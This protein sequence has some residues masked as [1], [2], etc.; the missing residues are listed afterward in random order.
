MS[1]QPSESGI[2]FACSSRDSFDSWFTIFTFFEKNVIRQSTVE[3]IRDRFFSQVQRLSCRGILFEPD[4]AMFGKEF[5][6]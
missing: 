6:K 2:L 4:P 3:R 5:T 1:F